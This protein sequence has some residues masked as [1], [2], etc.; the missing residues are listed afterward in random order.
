METS[1]Y[2]DHLSNTDYQF[3]PFSC[4]IFFC[5]TL[6]DARML[7]TIYVTDSFE[8]H[9]WRSLEANFQIEQRT[10]T[11]NKNMQIKAKCSSE[12]FLIIEKSNSH[13]MTE[14]TANKAVICSSSQEIISEK[15]REIK[16]VVQVKTG[17][18]TVTK[19]WR[20]RARDDDERGERRKQR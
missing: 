1:Q 15:K 16:N 17:R 10:N 13:N 2:L 3:L 4:L 12:E 19:Q 6:F 9:A 7:C 5:Y 8:Y 14:K 18:V 20:P 11:Q